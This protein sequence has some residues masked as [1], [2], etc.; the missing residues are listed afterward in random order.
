MTRQYDIG[1]VVDQMRTWCIRLENDDN[2]EY[3]F[4]VDCLGISCDISCVHNFSISSA[5][6]WF[7]MP[8]LMCSEKPKPC[9]CRTLLLEIYNMYV[10]L[11]Y[12]S[13]H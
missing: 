3:D 9:D 10:S 12:R 5:L 11:K 7:T 13:M 2:E 4:L 8:L 6:Y 1:D